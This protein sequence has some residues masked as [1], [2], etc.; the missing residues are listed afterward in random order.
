MTHSPRLQNIRTIYKNHLYFYSNVQT[1]NE[2]KETIAFIF[3]LA[4][5]KLK[6]LGINLTEIQTLYSEKYKVLKGITE[7]LNKWKD[8]LRSGME[9][10]TVKMTVLPN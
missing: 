8:I 5:K 3:I 1:K 6:Y 9:D 10:N 7:D 2:T 4:S